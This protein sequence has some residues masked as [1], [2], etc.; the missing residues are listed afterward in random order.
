M[1]L[2]KMLKSTGLKVEPLEDIICDQPQFG[3]KAVVHDHMES[4]AQVQVD[5]MTCLYFVCW[6]FYFIIQC[7]Q[8]D[9]QTVPALR[10]VL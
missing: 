7:H 8:F 2:L 5:G 9:Q 10:I 4:F 3:G 1:S 6:N